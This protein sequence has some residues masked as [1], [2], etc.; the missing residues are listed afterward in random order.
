MRSG[1]RADCQAAREAILEAQVNAALSG[2]DLGEFEPVDSLA[3][4][5]EARYCRKRENGLGGRER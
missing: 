5:C 2:H 1:T 4:G 3:G